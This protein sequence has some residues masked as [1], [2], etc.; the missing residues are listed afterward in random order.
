MSEVEAIS[1]DKGVNTKKNPIFLEPDECVSCEGFDFRTAGQ[2]EARPS[3][4]A[5]YAIDVDPDSNI[6]GLTR[7]DSSLYASSKAYCPGG[8]AFFNYMYYREDTGTGWANISHLMGNARPRFANYNGFTFVVDGEGLKRA[9]LNERAYNWGIQN[10]T[11]APT[12]TVGAVGEPSADPYYCYVTFY[13]IFPNGHAYETGTSPANTITVTDQKIEWSNIP[14]CPYEGGGL[15]IHRRLYRTV[16][17][18]A[19][20]AA[21]ITDNYKKTFSDN[22][23]DATLQSSTLLPDTQSF[24]PPNDCTDIAVYLQRI[25]LVKDEYLY[26]TEAYKPFSWLSTSSAVVTTTGENLVACEVWG[27]QLYLATASR[28]RKL[29]GTDPDTWALKNTF[30]DSGVVNRYTLKKTKYGMLSLGYDGIYMFDGT[31]SKNITEKYLGTKLFTDLEDL[32]VCYSYYDGRHYKFYYASS[33]TTIDKCITIDLI[34]YPNFVVFNDDFI[35]TAIFYDFDEG[36]TYAAKDGY[37]YSESGSEEISASIQTGDRVFKSILKQKNLEYL[38]YDINTGGVDV[39]VDIYADDTLAHT[40]TLNSA[41]RIRK[42]SDK[43]PQI[44]GYRF[45]V[46]ISCSDSE[47]IIIYS[48]W[49]LAATY[50]GD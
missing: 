1:F 18:L 29:Q 36:I 35:A 14:I 4:S 20:L 11:I 12:L 27:D 44:D 46:K 33:G 8:Q 22:V 42:R 34:E 32:S 26:W 28:W 10:P 48:P 30:S 38:Y 17:G 9:F 21:T 16:S 23:T 19:Y 3:Y 13:V 5:L 37:E 6:N 45:S 25:F 15:V 40:I 24:P 41:T 50:F 43:F 39:T 31:I 7:Y 47:D 2:L 49:A